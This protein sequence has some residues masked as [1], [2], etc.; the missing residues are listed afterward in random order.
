MYITCVT[1]LRK[2][3]LENIVEK[4]EIAHFEQC[5]LFPLCFLCNLHLKFVL[6]ATFQLSHAASLNLGPSQNDVLRNG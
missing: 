6:I 5:Y 3:V 4:G 2:K 1:T